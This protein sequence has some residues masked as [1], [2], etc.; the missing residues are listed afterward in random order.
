MPEIYLTPDMVNSTATQITNQ[1]QQLEG[2]MKAIDQLVVNLQANWKGDAQKAFATSWAAK[3]GTYD[4][5]IKQG[6]QPFAD[7][8]KKYVTTMQGADQIA[9]F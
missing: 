5:F 2:F 9:K 6:L 1:K 3:R 7:F 4:N 8:L